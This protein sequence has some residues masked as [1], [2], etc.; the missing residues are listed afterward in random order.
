MLPDA[1]D[2][3]PLDNAPTAFLSSANRVEQ[4]VVEHD[5]V[6]LNVIVILAYDVTDPPA[7]G[8]KSV[9]EIAVAKYCVECGLQLPEHAHFC[10][11]CGSQQR[12]QE[13]IAA[14]PRNTRSTFTNESS[15]PS[16]ATSIQWEYC[17]IIEYSGFTGKKFIARAT[18]PR[19]SYEVAK[20]H[21]FRNFDSGLVNS[22][23]ISLLVQKIVGLG[24][25][26]QTSG[27]NWYSYRF[28]RQVGR[29]L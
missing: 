24:W 29:K 14:A 27:S 13:E 10:D 26:A 12:T 4:L 2:L 22:Q 11:S 3:V 23:N 1:A 25:E 20:T 21:A 16:V 15:A 19:G 5:S 9:V 7:S 18:G 17:E 28:R 6:S 8:R